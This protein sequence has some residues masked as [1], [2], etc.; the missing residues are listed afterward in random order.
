MIL[1]DI[2]NTDVND[3]LFSDLG[4]TVS[5]KRDDT[6]YEVVAIIL[7]DRFGSQEDFTV[8]SK[9]IIFVAAEEIKEKGLETPHPHDVVADRWEVETVRK[10]GGLWELNCYE[11]MWAGKQY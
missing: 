6:E 1:E 5:Y 8:E 3:V 9:A 4:K 10:V 11:A 7:E 2:W